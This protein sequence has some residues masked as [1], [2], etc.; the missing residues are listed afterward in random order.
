VVPF[1]LTSTIKAAPVGAVFTTTLT[2][3][4]VKVHGATMVGALSVPVVNVP[5]TA[6]LR[7]VLI[8]DVSAASIS[9]FHVA[10]IN[11]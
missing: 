9:F 8:V 2:L 6:K 10:G 1:L 7:V 11:L 5:T 3:T 4:M